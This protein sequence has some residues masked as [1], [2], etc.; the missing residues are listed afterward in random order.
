[1]GRIVFTIAE[2]AKLL[3]LGERTVYDAVRRGQLE[4]TKFRKRWLIPVDAL[5]RLLDKERPSRTVDERSD[6]DVP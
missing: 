6:S 3:G 4:A 2:V 5:A 1:M